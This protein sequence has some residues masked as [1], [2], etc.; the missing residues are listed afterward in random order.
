MRCC[1]SVRAAVPFLFLVIV[2]ALTVLVSGCRTAPSDVPVQASLDRSDDAAAVPSRKAAVR[3]AVRIPHVSSVS[4]TIRAVG[5]VPT[6]TFQ[7]TFYRQNPNLVKVLT[8]FKKVTPSNGIASASFDSVPEMSVVAK[9]IMENCH[10]PGTD[11]TKFSDFR[12][13]ADLS[14]GENTVVVEPVDSK[15]LGDLAASILETQ[16]DKGKPL[17]ISSTDLVA[18]VLESIG[19]VTGNG[20]EAF[21]E[22]ITNPTVDRPVIKGLSFTGVTG[23]Q[24]K[25]GTDRPCTAQI[26]YGLT[27]AYGKSAVSAVATITHSIALPA[28]A[29]GTYFFRIT[30]RDATGTEAILETRLSTTMEVSLPIEVSGMTGHSLAIILRNLPRGFA[31]NAPFM[32]Q[33]GVSSKLW[34]SFEYDEKTTK[35]VYLGGGGTEIFTVDAFRSIRFLG[36]LPVGTVVEV[37]NDLTDQKICDVIIK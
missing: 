30:A 1:Q 19:D 8:L 23:F 3:F 21:L 16:A 37:V 26:A 34:E 32:T 12:G 22:K 25:F 28:L 9:I 27:D 35:L 11:A 15:T 10:I 2:F 6:V 13:V 24:L 33:S 7:L 4:P 31:I 36:H 20:Y 29:A 5:A 18:G 17:P 14:S